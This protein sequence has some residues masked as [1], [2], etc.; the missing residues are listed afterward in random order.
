MAA[1]PST[2]QPEASKGSPRSL[3][4]LAMSAYLSSLEDACAVYIQERN[5]AAVFPSGS[6]YNFTFVPKSRV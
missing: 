2:G 3:E 6:Y 4:D 5:D 1:C